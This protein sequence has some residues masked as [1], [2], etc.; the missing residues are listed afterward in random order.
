MI[1]YAYIL[2]VIGH[3]LAKLRF[4]TISATSCY[5]SLVNN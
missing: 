4:A 1:S 3:I 5:V 2:S